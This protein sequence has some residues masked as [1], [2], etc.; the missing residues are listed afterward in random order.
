MK[1]IFMAIASVVLACG[2]GVAAVGC[3]ASDT[4]N[5]YN[6]DSASGTRAAFIELLGID[7]T[8]S[9]S[10]THLDVYKRQ[11]GSREEIAEQTRAAVHAAKGEEK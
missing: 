4:I 10:Y 6:R 3:G 2:I 11:Q 5:V 9:V 1:K 7:E 8:E